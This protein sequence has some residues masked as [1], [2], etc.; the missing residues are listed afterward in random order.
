MNQVVRI[1]RN[2]IELVSSNLKENECSKVSRIDF[3]RA[4]NWA[5]SRF[6][7]ICT[8]PVSTESRACLRLSGNAWQG[9]SEDSFPFRRSAAPHQLYYPMSRGFS[10]GFRDFTFPGILSFNPI[11]SYIFGRW[12]DRGV[13]QDQGNTIIIRIASA[14]RLYAQI[15]Q[16]VDN[17]IRQ[18]SGNICICITH[19]EFKTFSTHNL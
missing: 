19:T 9:N 7:S 14:E 4:S 10:L 6:E 3:Q 8:V 1:E 5:S 2:L 15:E 11:K 18:V 13:F 16:L 17:C 12:D